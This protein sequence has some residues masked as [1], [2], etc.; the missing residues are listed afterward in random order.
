MKQKYSCLES[1]S[2]ISISLLHQDGAKN[3]SPT[4]RTSARWFL[5]TEDVAD[6][7]RKRFLVIKRRK[8]LIGISAA[9]VSAP[10][11]VRVGSLMT[12]R[13]IVMPV[14]KNYYQHYGFCDRLWV[15]WRYESGELRGPALMRMIE[16]QILQVPPAILAYDLARWG[17]GELSLA[18]R[19]R[20][21]EA[22]WPR[23]K[24]FHHLIRTRTV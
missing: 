1:R 23:V 10:A 6:R 16:E 8:F 19:E 4:C 20:R 9:V 7:Q 11:I 17:T 12:V 18:A 15:K 24:D 2:G 3:A 5:R 22:L 21:R 13:G 14:H